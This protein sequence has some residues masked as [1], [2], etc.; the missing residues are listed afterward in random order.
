M[1]FSFVKFQ[2]G[3]SSYPH[4]LFSF[5]PNHVH[6]FSAL[7]LNVMLSFILL[8]LLNKNFF[9]Q[10]F[11]FLQV[12]WVYFLFDNFHGCHN[13][14]FLWV[15]WNFGSETHLAYEYFSSL[16]MFTYLWLDVWL[17]LRSILQGT[18][19][20]SNRIPDPWRGLSLTGSLS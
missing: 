19:G 20:Q 1:I 4:V 6:Y 15:S 17:L 13:I 8:E 16:Y 5:L 2:S 12:G 14:Y 7:F 18:L 11:V 9:R 10:Y 3:S